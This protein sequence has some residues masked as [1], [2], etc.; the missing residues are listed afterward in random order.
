MARIPRE[1]MRSLLKHLLTAAKL[2]DICMAPTRQQ[3]ELLSATDEMYALIVGGKRE[4]SALRLGCR[5]LADAAEGVGWAEDRGIKLICTI[6][7]M[8]V[9]S[10]EAWKRLPFELAAE[11]D[12]VKQCVRKNHAPMGG[13]Y[14]LDHAERIQT[15]YGSDLDVK[16]V[17]TLVCLHSTSS[18]GCAAIG[19]DDSKLRQKTAACIRDMLVQ[20]E[21]EIP[22]D[23]AWLNK[24]V[25]LASLLR[26]ADTRR[27]GT[28]LTAIDEARLFYETRDGKVELF[29]ERNDMLQRI[30]DRSAREILLSE[31][32]TEFGEVRLS[33]NSAEWEITHRLR[34]R[35]WQQKE[36][37]N[38]FCD[39]R[40][41]SYIRE[42]V[43]AE[44]APG[45]ELRHL[46]ELE[47]E[48]EGSPEA[49]EEVCRLAEKGMDGVK[50]RII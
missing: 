7:G 45:R 19:Y 46:L 15:V 26:L 33:N 34:V 43:T 1:D 12:A 11:H 44:L 5:R 47:L 25:T 13:L 27:S 24:A 18:S 36:L 22:D 4:P 48:G 3:I 20:R 39:Q 9:I 14:V 32:C 23:A 41:K 6:C 10:D 35:G 29:V 50:I 21:M 49:R 42:I 16:L 38:L 2:H 30:T 8:P 28:R 17:A 37:R 40:L 31:S